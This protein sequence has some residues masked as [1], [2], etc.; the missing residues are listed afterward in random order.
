MSTARRGIILDRDGTLIDVVRDEE[1][2]TLSVAFH[3]DQLRF[4][5]GV[6]DGLRALSQ[7]GFV[8]AIATNQPGPAKGQFSR[9]AVERT[10]LALIARLAD[11][12]V[13]I[14]ALEV[15]LHHPQGG[16]GGDPTLIG[17]CACRKPKPGLLHALISGL[18][19]DPSRSFMIG[20]SPS[21]VEA[22]RLA[23]MRAGLLFSR[24]RCELCP[25]RGG[26]PGKPELVAARFDDLARLILAA[27]SPLA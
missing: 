3:P 4:L 20:D 7:A 21:D 8:L 13:S 5:P 18:G 6:L 25:L 23:S 1:T 19:L 27:P 2:G 24:D 11:A 22:A 16:P 15:C 9:A 26:P 12:G 17:D 14:A 10:N